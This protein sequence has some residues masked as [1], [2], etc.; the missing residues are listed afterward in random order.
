MKPLLFLLLCCLLASTALPGQINWEDAP[1]D[2]LEVLLTTLPDSHRHRPGIWNE[3]GYKY[4]KKNPERARA[5]AEKAS[6]LAIRLNDRAAQSNSMVI[7]GHLALKVGKL[8]TAIH[9]Y[10]EALTLREDLKD[11]RGMASCYNSLGLVSKYRES[12]LEK[13]EDYFQMGLKAL[14][15]YAG[16]KDADE[17]RAKIYNNLGD[18]YFRTGRYEE[19]LDAFNASK[20][21][22]PPEKRGPLFL[23]EAACLLNLGLFTTADKKLHEALS[24]FRN[25]KD[26]SNLAK[27]FLQMEALK[28]S[29]GQLDSADHYWIKAFALNSYLSAADQAILQRNKGNISWARGNTEAALAHFQNA[30]IGFD[31]LSNYAELAKLWFEMG[32]IYFEREDYEAA[33]ALYEKGWNL[34]DGHSLLL[35]ELERRLLSYLSSAYE[36]NGQLDK[37]YSAITQYT[38]RVD[39]VQ[40]SREMAM[41][42]TNRETADLLEQERLQSNRRAEKSKFQLLLSALAI[43]LLLSAFIIAVLMAFKINDKK[44]L[45]LKDKRLAEQ[46]LGNALNQLEHKSNYMLLDESERTMH[47]VSKELHDSL[48]GMLSTIKLYFVD[49][50]KKISALR[51]EN[52]SQFEK[53][54]ALLDEVADEVRRISRKA[55]PANLPD[56]SLMEK[57]ESIINHI[58]C[59]EQI[60]VEFTAHGMQERLDPVRERKLCRIIYILVHNVLEHAQASWFS[61]QLNRFGEELVVM[62]ED[63]GKGFDPVKVKEKGGT[64]L[65]HLHALCAELGAIAQFDSD[66]GSGTSVT[67]KMPIL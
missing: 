28:F 47:S 39:S 43:A 50:N 46:R 14:D 58:R 38:S 54:N 19:A 12:D 49:L 5:Y 51:E 60:D 57:V 37:A 31:S 9:Y 17:L 45:A 10:S 8:D 29:Q 56:R 66:T 30:L 33:I 59:T 6:A 27:A 62:V 26:T 18:L 3:L 55:S 4:W 16:S 34:I 41:A 40:F 11:Y 2:S 21:L 35:P 7:F 24:L 53:A 13:S 52:K 1:A 63:N 36:L 22:R 48:G 65:H 67:I 42:Q 20:A 23:N 44:A 15:Q 61:L 32:S 25:A 64:G